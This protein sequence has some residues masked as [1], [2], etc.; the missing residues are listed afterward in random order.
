MSLALKT[1][2]TTEVGC[3]CHLQFRMVG[4]RGGEVGGKQ[5]IYSRNLC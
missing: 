1:S 4:E 2:L 5:G 3:Q